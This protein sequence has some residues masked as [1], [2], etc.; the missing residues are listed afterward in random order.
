MKQKK[1]KF[2]CVLCGKIPKKG[3]YYMPSTKDNCDHFYCDDCVPRGCSCNWDLN[4]G[5]DYGSE[6][7][8]DSKNYHEILDEKHRPLPCCEYSFVDN[9]FEV[10]QRTTK[11]KEIV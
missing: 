8:T 5:I 9:E 7:A 4:E 1:L 11:I 3:W 2:K 10:K 6:A